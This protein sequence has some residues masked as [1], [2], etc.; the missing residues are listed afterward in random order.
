MRDESLPMDDWKLPN[1]AAAA[2][3]GPEDGS[4]A[5]VNDGETLLAEHEHDESD[6]EEKEAEAGLGRRKS[7]KSTL[8]MILVTTATLAARRILNGGFRELFSVPLPWMQ[9]LECNNT[10]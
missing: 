6:D 1:Y 5:N 9:V 4:A 7:I 8:W 2:G 10:C 3:R